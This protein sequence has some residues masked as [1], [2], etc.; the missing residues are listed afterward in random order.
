[1]PYRE[2]QSNQQKKIVTL[3]DLMNERFSQITPDALLKVQV[4][5]AQEARV[6]QMRWVTLGIATGWIALGTTASTVLYLLTKS[7]FAYLPITVALPT[8]Y[9]IIRD[10]FIFL[11]WTPERY[12]LEELKQSHKARMRELKYEARQK[13]KN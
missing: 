8:T 5:E 13:S 1:V 3:D 4:Q 12:K 6:W 2:S 11:F 7:G 9:L 10:I